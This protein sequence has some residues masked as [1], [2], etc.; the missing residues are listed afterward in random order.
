M[1]GGLQGLAIAAGC[2]WNGFRR[3]RNL[4]K[5]LVCS[6]STALLHQ[7]R[8]IDLRVVLLAS[9]VIAF[10]IEVA[11]AAP[12]GS[13]TRVE[14]QAQV[15]A[16]PAAVG[17]PVQ[18]N[19]ELR[20]GP[21]ARLEVTFTDGT[22]LT[23][24]EN[25]KVV[26]DRYV[27]N[28]DESVGQLAV[29]T[30]VAAFRMATG[31]L[32]EMKDRQVN[33]T[34]PFAALAVRGTDFWWGPINGHYGALLVNN[35]MVD[36]SGDKCDDKQSDG[37]DDHKR[38]CRCKVTLDKPGEG[39]D[40]RRYECPGAPY[41]WPPG[42]IEAALSTTEFGLALGPGQLI[43]AVGAAGVLGG[44]LGSTAGNDDHKPTVS[45]MNDGGGGGGGGGGGQHP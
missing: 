29:S 45:D 7:F 5:L 42:Q 36:V 25:A 35:S 16:A 4:L 12:V 40:I 33:V 28:P 21:K 41:M 20:T 10:S 2:G 32:N 18:L 23:L 1:G 19:D 9:L 14:N 27:Y 43:P 13:I 30:T 44:F 34:T 3:K 24:G 31:K 6:F 26:V 8:A 38:R 15:G 39:T 22:K 17:T 11:A 37:D